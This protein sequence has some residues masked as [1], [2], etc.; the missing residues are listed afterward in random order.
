MTIDTEDQ[1][2][3]EVGHVTERTGKNVMTKGDTG[4]RGSIK[5]TN[6]ATKHMKRTLTGHCALNCI[7]WPIH[8]INSQLCKVN[9]HSSKYYLPNVKTHVYRN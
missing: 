5:N 9:L 8:E 3:A 4:M 1:S 6:P 2:V 7:H